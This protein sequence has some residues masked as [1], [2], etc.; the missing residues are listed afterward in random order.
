[1]AT[2]ALLTWPD[3]RSGIVQPIARFDLEK[4]QNMAAAGD[5]VDFPDRAAPIT[6]HDAPTREAQIDPGNG[7]SHPAML[8]GP[9]P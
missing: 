8:P 2:A 3:R 5:D 6:R 4:G 1:M 9:S 7:F